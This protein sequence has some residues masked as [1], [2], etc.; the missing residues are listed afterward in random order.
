MDLGSWVTSAE[1]QEK[2]RLQC[3]FIWISSLS[4]MLDGQNHKLE[5]RY[6]LISA[7]E[8]GKYFH[9]CYT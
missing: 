8:E 9:I 2:E 1:N 5:R 6:F 4:R 7:K 3:F